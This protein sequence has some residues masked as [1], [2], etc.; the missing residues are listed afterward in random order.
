MMMT[1]LLIISSSDDGAFE[2]MKQANI[3]PAVTD[4]TNIDEAV[5]AYLA[6]SLEN[7]VEKLH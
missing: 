2:N 4:V 7:H 3:R 5:Q 6:G 1:R